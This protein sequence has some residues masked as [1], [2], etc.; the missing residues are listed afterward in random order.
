[1]ENDNL[2]IKE[3]MSEQMLLME[4]L[5]ELMME[6]KDEILQKKNARWVKAK[7]H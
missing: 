6:L 4:W 5:D 3:S 7:D 1:M 2:L